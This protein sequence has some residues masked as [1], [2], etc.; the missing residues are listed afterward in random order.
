MAQ[1]P[2]SSDSEDFDDR[3]EYQYDSAGEEQL[4]VSAQ[5][6]L[7]LSGGNYRGKSLLKLSIPA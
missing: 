5:T 4:G 3:E 6:L 1:G 2:L 7:H